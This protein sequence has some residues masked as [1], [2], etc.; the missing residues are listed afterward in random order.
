MLRLLRI[1]LGV[2][3]QGP[4]YSSHLPHTVWTM[5]AVWSGLHSSHACMACCVVMSLTAA[6]SVCGVA[7]VHSVGQH[8]SKLSLACYCGRV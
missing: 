6:A 2:P 3:D 5:Q 8:N 7:L 4:Q 1:V